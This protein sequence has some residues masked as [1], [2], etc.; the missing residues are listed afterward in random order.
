MAR[1]S[2]PDTV[3]AVLYR[4]ISGPAGQLRDWNLFRRLFIPTGQL[5][6]TGRTPQGQVRYRAMTPEDYVQRSGPMLEQRGFFEAETHRAVEQYGHVYHAF[7][8]YE[9]RALATDATPFARGI[10]SIQLLQSGGRWWVVSILWGDEQATAMPVPAQ[11]LPGG[12]AVGHLML[13]HSTLDIR[14]SW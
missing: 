10:N 13:R 3:I 8:T 9:S 14:C 4:V 1:F 7:S 6:G 5:I 11:Y 12:T 2:L